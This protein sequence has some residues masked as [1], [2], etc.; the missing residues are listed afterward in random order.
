MVA[1]RKLFTVWFVA[2]V[3]FISMETMLAQVH[4]GGAQV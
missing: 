1:M 3:I 2:L 4:D